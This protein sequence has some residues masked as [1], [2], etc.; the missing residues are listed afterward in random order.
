MPAVAVP[1]LWDSQTLLDDTRYV[2]RPLDGRPASLLAAIVSNAP[3][4]RGN[5]MGTIGKSSGQWQVGL[6][7]SRGV[8]G[9][10][11]GLVESAY[12]PGLN[13]VPGAAGTGNSIGIRGVVATPVAPYDQPHILIQTSFG[14][15]HAEYI[16]PREYAQV[17]EF[18]VAAY[19]TAGT[20]A[21][22]ADGVLLR[23]ITGAPAGTW[24]PAASI[25][26]NGSVGINASPEYPIAGFTDWTETV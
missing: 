14:G 6:I 24:F 11:V 13:D 12:V 7:N 26:S 9:F 1:V 4:H 19:L 17:G 15:V 3:E 18:T 22:Y 2:L 8:D 16:H 20:V 10:Y 23:T 25:L 21:I 5:V